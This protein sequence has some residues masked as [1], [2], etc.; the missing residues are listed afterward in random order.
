MRLGDLGMQIRKEFPKFKIVRKSTSTLM[1]AIDIFLKVIT[2]GQMKRFMTF[3]T[4]V[5]TTVYVFEE[6]SER[7]TTSRIIILRHERVHMRQR[8]KYGSFLFTFL[9]LFFPFP[10]FFAYYRRKFEMEAYEE[11]MKSLVDLLPAT[12]KRTLRSS[13]F[14]E[15]MVK[16]FTT[17]EYFWM[18]PFKGAI[19]RWYDEAVKRLES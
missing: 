15:A 12:S 3:V 14:K 4:T 6:W 7:S 19:S 1:K 18:W 9:Y 11:T 13:T 17:A 16:H 2:F 10:V 8:K 5:G